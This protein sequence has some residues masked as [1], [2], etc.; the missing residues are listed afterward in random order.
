MTRA[1]ECRMAEDGRHFLW[2]HECN[3]E[4]LDTGSNWHPDETLPLDDQRGWRVEQ[5]DPLTVSPSILCV[6]CQTHG[7]WRDGAWVGV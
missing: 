5:V 6:S 7:F 1:P 4:F 3:F 2:S